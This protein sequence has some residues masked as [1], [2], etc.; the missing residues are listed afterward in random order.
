MS[1][2]VLD[3]GPRPLSRPALS[4][5]LSTYNQPEWLRKALLGYARQDFRDFE[6]I[7]ADDGS[8]D[9]T[10]AMIEAL[11]EGYPVA[12][13]HVWHPDNGF[14]KCE[15]LNRASEAARADYLVFSDG[16]CIP[17]A[18]FLSVHHALREPGRFLS[19]GYVKLP[20]ATSQAIDPAAIEAGDFVRP[21][22]LRANGCAARDISRKLTVQGRWAW[23]WDQLSTAKASWNGHNA[24]GWKADLLRVNGFDTRMQYG[25]QDREFGERLENAG[26][27]GKRIRH[28]AICVHLDHPRGYATE[29]SIQRNRAIR[30]ETRRLRSTWAVNGLVT[31]PQVPPASQPPAEAARRAA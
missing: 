24:S 12:L 6:L 16:D 20:M 21:D 28:R 31:S 26:I 4:V 17:R 14:Q 7:I 3:L 30:A 10:R 25:G 9:A 15:I 13:R 5:V 2:R 27:R 8:D 23:L 19:G 11:G 22:W 1:L 29:A 18:D